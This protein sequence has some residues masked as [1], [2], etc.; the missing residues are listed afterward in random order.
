MNLLKKLPKDCG[1]DSKLRLRLVWTSDHAIKLVAVERNSAGNCVT[2]ARCLPVVSDRLA[3]F[4][5]PL[6]HLLAEVV[7]ESGIS[8]GSECVFSLP[9]SLMSYQTLD[10]NEP[11]TAEEVSFHAQNAM[12]EILGNEID[13]VT[14][15]YWRNCNDRNSSIEGATG[16]LHLVWT[17]AEQADRLTRSL[18]KNGL[19][20]RS[21]TLP[22][23]PCNP[24]C[25][26]RQPDVSWSSISDVAKLPL[27]GV[28]L[29]VLNTYVA[30]YSSTMSRPVS[31]C[32]SLFGGYRRGR[33]TE[34]L[35]N[36]R[37]R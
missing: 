1:G 22:Q 33:V 3:I 21:S 9:S 8:R 2:S 11:L 26:D 29:E 25:K 28:T 24:L 16:P 36:Q 6:E 20:R 27:Y 5:G 14:F 4:E 19:R 15:D 31:L 32:Y 34:V 23:R 10:C 13:R 30:G 7:S 18:Y 12:M 37:Q 17:F 35:R